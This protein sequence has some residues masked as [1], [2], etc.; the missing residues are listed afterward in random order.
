MS[1]WQP[2][3]T[4]P[5]DGSYFVTIRIDDEIASE[6]E[7]GKYEPYKHH[8]YEE[9]SNGLYRRV[10]V[11]YMEFTHNNFHRSTHWLPLPALPKASPQYPTPTPGSTP[12]TSSSRDDQKCEPA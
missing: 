1:E 12:A 5:R 7:I 2:I 9:A 3:E 8:K 10:E 11:V 4:A 6:P